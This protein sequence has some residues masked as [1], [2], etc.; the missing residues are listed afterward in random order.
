MSKA[1][2][3]NVSV[4]FP[5]VVISLVECIWVQRSNSRPGF[6]LEQ[7]PRPERAIKA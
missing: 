5:C 1:Q 2:P 3:T 4:E 6:P 7:A